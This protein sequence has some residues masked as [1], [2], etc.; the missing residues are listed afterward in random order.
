LPAHL[1]D[2]IGRVRAKTRLPLAVG[3]GISQPEHVAAVGTI[4]D[5]AVVGSALIEVIDHSTPDERLGA[6][7]AF[8]AKLADAAASPAGAR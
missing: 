6:V 8:V 3:F 1:P 5:A 4:A 2:F 7:R